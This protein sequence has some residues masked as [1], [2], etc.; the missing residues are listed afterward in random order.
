MK[1]QYKFKI[2]SRLPQKKANIAG[3]RLHKI[4]GRSGVLAPEE[5][6][7]DARSGESP[8]HDFFEWDDTAAAEKHRLEQARHLVRSIVVVLSGPAEGRE[9]KAYVHFRK[10]PDADD[11]DSPYIAT[12]KVLAD[13]VLRARLLRQALRDVEAW[14]AKYRDLSELAAIFAAVDGAKKKKTA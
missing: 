4:A 10:D 8:L 5:V 14:R 3:R 13:S 1:Q 12:C 6:L 2:G 11:I 7:E 9:T